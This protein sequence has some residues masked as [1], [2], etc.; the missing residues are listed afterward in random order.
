MQRVHED[1]EPRRHGPD[2]PFI[3]LY[4]KFRNGM[5]A[6]TSEIWYAQSD[7]LANIDRIVGYASSRK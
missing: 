2:L 7:R 6:Q 5:S 3:K 1:L 4:R